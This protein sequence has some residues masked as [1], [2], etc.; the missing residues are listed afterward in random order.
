MCQCNSI[1]DRSWWRSSHLTPPATRP[2][3]D[4][5][6]RSDSKNARAG[7]KLLAGEVDD[8]RGFRIPPFLCRKAASHADV[9][10]AADQPLRQQ[11]RAVA[12]RP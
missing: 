9:N 5:T 12:V 2:G 1:Q 7:V 11:D 8:F 4:R 10:A 3:E 6:P